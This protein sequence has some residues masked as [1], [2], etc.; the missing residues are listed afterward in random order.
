MKYTMRQA[1]DFP[2][3]V[4]KRIIRNIETGMH[5]M[6]RIHRHHWRGMKSGRIAS[7]KFTHDSDEYTLAEAI[8]GTEDNPYEVAAANDYDSKVAWLHTVN[9]TWAKIV[10]LHFACGRT[11]PEIGQEMGIPASL[12]SKKCSNGVNR[13]RWR[14]CPEK[15]TNEAAAHKQ[16]R[17]R[18]IL[19][20]L[21]ASA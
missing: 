3:F 6:A 4:E 13:L 14:Y 10:H 18:R 9:P 8:A 5:R 21:R 19:G 1:V 2:A 17:H 16:R 7:V 11:F 12:A 15:W 20:M